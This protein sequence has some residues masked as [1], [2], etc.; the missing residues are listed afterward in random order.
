MQAVGQEGLECSRGP[1]A[2]DTDLGVISMWMAREA[3]RGWRCQGRED[4]VK[5]RRPRTGP[6]GPSL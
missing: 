5:R 2:E 6:I 4:G 3:L 1:G